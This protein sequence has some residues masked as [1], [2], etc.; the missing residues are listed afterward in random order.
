MKSDTQPQTLPHDS[1]SKRK[2]EREFKQIYD[3]YAKL[4]FYISFRIVENA[5][6]AEDAVNEAF[7]N[8]FNN[9]YDIKNKKY[10][11]VSSVKNI[12][13]NILQKRKNVKY[14]SIE[15]NNI[16]VE[17]KNQELLINSFYYDLKSFLSDEEI[18]IL[19]DHVIY[20]LTFS[21]IAKMRNTTKFSISSKYRRIKEKVKKHFKEE[22]L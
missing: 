11:L 4:L 7:L 1:D 6:D 14:I 15:D 20:S 8:F 18:D 9:Y 3:K 2:L 5:S 17:D 12:S 16:D 19:F 10:Y 13:Y 22:K 21:E